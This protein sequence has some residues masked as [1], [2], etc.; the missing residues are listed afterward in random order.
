[1]KIYL[2][3]EG[4]IIVLMILGYWFFGFFKK[5]FSLSGSGANEEQI[6]DDFYK[7]CSFE[8][9]VNEYVRSNEEKRRVEVKAKRPFGK[10]IYI[11]KNKIMITPFENE[12]ES[13]IKTSAYL[14][15]LEL[16]IKEI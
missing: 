15:Y 4:A 9:L 16:K 10:E 3:G 1:M 2:I 8:F 12:D 6:S 13:L 14:E 7:E 5:K 11:T